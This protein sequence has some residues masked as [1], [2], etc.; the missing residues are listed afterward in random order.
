[1]ASGARGRKGWPQILRDLNGAMAR[2]FLAIAAALT[3][4]WFAAVPANAQ[5]PFEDRLAA[6]RLAAVEPGLYQAGEQVA[7][8]LD[9]DGRN[10]LLR[11]AGDPEI[12]V[13]YVNHAS[14]G[15]RVLKYDSGETV[16]K[17]AG[18]GGIT[19][20]TDKEPGGLAAVRTGDSMPPSPPE[21]SLDEVKHAASDEAQ[22]LAYMHRLNLNFTAPWNALAGDD[23]L[24]AW[25]F[26][27]IENTAR[28]IG[29]FASS[30][31]GRRA[32][33]AHVGIVL[34]TAG[35]KPTLRLGGKELIVTFDPAKGYAG[36]AS[37]RAI[38]RALGKIFHIA[39]KTD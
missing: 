20:Y 22:H 1:M 25:S 34:V 33:A 9:R 5:S 10:F 30:A 3:L 13:L 12:F 39:P 26:D 27:T 37:S 8:T 36:R 18:W 21:V 6:D 14:L 17:V 32:L 7:F 19:L 38:A 15:G 16:L 2:P 35:A 11:F 24:R 29:R 23:G 28:G 4:A 31:E